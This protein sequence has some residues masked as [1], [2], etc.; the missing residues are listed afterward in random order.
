MSYP[1][2]KLDEDNL[3]RIT[4]LQSARQLEKM[5][6]L[7]IIKSPEPGTPAKFLECVA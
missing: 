4:F 5:G 2:T 7:R 1:K 3:N 6:V